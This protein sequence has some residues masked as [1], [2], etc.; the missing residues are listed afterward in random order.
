MVGGI[1]RKAEKEKKK[2]VVKT[3][4]PQQKQQPVQQQAVTGHPNLN[5]QGPVQPGIS[6]KIFRRTGESVPIAAE[7][8]IGAT[9]SGN[10]TIQQQPTTQPSGGAVFGGAIERGLSVLDPSFEA[11]DKLISGPRDPVTGEILQLQAVATA[12]PIG[13]GSFAGA[14]DVPF[15]AR[16]AIKKAFPGATK[17]QIGQIEWQLGV[18]RVTTRAKGMINAK[19]LG[20]LGKAFA[21]VLNPTTLK[22]FGVLGI[23]AAVMS[24]IF[25]GKWG[26][27]EAPEPISFTMSKIYEQALDSGNWTLYK[28][29][30]AAR[31]EI[32]NTTWIQDIVLDTPLAPI[33]GTSSKTKGIIEAGILLDKLAREAEEL[34]LTGGTI[35]DSMRRSREEKLANEKAITDYYNEQRLITADALRESN[36]EQDEESRKLWLKHKQ[37]IIKLEREERETEAKFWLEYNK[38]KIKLQEE[39][40]PSKLGFGLL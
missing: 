39:N 25:F 7:G 33:V 17:A 40:R 19:S 13:P 32:T 11:L 22:I 20:L 23:V 34:Q 30:A 8:T 12:L 5:V 21:K 26:Q 36:R 10:R 18:M 24:P 37:D 27:A 35:E 14:K 2:T 16:S 9:S 28:E 29:A 31:D 4:V 3:P 1:K 38:L 6:E 15:I